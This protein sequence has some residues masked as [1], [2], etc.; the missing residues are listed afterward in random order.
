MALSHP[1]KYIAST[2]LHEAREVLTMRVTV[3]N[4]TMTFA[5]R[6]NHVDTSAP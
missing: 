3:H 6:L 5:S 4:T 1:D 2:L